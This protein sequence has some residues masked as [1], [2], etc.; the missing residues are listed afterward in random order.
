MTDWR[1]I[2][3][4]VNQA[5]IRTYRESLPVQYIPAETGVPIPVVLFFESS[6][7][8]IDA[9]TSISRHVYRPYAFVRLE[10]LGRDPADGDTIVV[11]GTTY[12]VTHEERD[13]YGG[14]TLFMGRID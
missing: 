2:A 1:G 9:N 3:D 10:D 5:V 8:E 4:R 13:G 12:L 11:Q 7:F 6:A 14:V